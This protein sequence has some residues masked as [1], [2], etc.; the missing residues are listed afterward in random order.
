MRG[1]L[2]PVPYKKFLVLQ[3]KFYLSSLSL[4]ILLSVMRRKCIDLIPAAFLRQLA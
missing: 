1:A 4:F 3:G 2:P